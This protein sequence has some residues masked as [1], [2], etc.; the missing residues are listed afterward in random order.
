MKI[1]IK[2]FTL[3]DNI[4]DEFVSLL[5]K[6]LSCNSYK[7]IKDNV[8]NTNNFYCYFGNS[9]ISVYDINNRKKIVLIEF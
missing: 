9:H 7:E 3:Q 6:I 4:K 8:K 1:E 5:S 2:N